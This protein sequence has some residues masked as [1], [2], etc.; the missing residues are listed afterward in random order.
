VG[1]L[2]I[3]NSLQRVSLPLAIEAGLLATVFLLVRHAP[4]QASFANHSAPGSIW[5]LIFAAGIAGL[6]AFIPLGIVLLQ[7]ARALAAV[8]YG[9]I[10][11]EEID[12]LDAHQVD[13]VVGMA[14]YTGQ[15]PLDRYA[16]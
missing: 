3:W 6:T 11:W 5:P 1:G 13:A 2:E 15:L 12:R 10:T 4:V 8:P 16:K 9:I 14:V 7:A